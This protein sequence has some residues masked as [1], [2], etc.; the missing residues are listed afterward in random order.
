MSTFLFPMIF[1]S[2]LSSI[3]PRHPYPSLQ[4]LC[5]RCENRD[6][7]EVVKIFVKQCP[8]LVTFGCK[9]V[10]SS[11]SYDCRQSLWKTVIKECVELEHIQL[12][13]IYLEDAIKCIRCTVSRWSLE[14]RRKLK[15]RTLSAMDKV[16]SDITHRIAD[17]LPGLQE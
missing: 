14:Q 12:Y 9:C 11:I 7:I 8:H 15:L 1:S 3:L 4:Q 13:G 10:F 16:G 2:L 5:I 17:L 6:E